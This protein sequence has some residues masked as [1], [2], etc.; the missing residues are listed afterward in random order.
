MK[1]FSPAQVILTT[2]FGLGV[3][4]LAI[5]TTSN[6]HDRNFEISQYDGRD[7]L[8]DG[9]LD[10]RWQY[11]DDVLMYRD[12]HQDLLEYRDYNDDLFE[13][14]SYEYDLKDREYYDSDLEE[15]GYLGLAEDAVKGVVDIVG[16]IKASVAKDKDDRGRYTQ[17]LVQKT[18]QQ[19]PRFNIVVCHTDHEKKFDGKEGVDWGHSHQEFKARVGGTIGYEIYWFKSGWFHRKGDGGYLNWSWSGNAVKKEKNG[20]MLT[21]AK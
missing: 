3:I 15:R 1:Y 9:D 13:S 8:F 16:G 14:R 4:G 6:F 18:A 21:F 11:D 10:A 5:P 12:Y 7:L 2:F 17:D 20:A 19:H